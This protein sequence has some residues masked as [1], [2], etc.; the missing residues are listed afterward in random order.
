VILLFFAQLF[1]ANV[2]NL[3]ICTYLR[4]KLSGASFTTLHVIERLS[5][6]EMVIGDSIEPLP[7]F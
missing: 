7:S 2:K 4:E 6:G 5:F 3:Y 1:I